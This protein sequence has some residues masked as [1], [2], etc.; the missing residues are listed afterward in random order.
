[1]RI[2]YLLFIILLS[3]SFICISNVDALTTTKV[4]VYGGTNIRN[5]TSNGY[6]N[7]IKAKYMDNLVIIN[8]KTISAKYCSKGL[9]KVK[10]NNIIGYV[11]SDSISS[12]NT[13]LVKSKT[14]LRNGKGTNY[15][16]YKKLSKNTMLTLKTTKV[17][18]KSR[19]C[20][21]GW[22]KVLIDGTTKY[23]CK[24]NT[25]RYTDKNTLLV[26]SKKGAILSKSK[27]NR[28]YTS[29]SYMSSL[30]LYKNKKYSGKNCPSKYYRVK[31]NNS[32]Y[33]VCSS[34]VLLSKTSGV[35]VSNGSLTVRSSN[36]SSS[37]QINTL[38]YSNLVGLINTTKYKGNGC[39][40]GFYKIYLDGRVGYA[41]SNFISTSNNVASTNKNISIKENSN[42]NSKN[43][44]S[45]N[46]NINVALLGIGKYSGS[47]CSS[48]YYK[49]TYDNR[50]GYICSGDTDFRN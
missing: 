33:Y 44:G 19:S 8:N 6:K 47:G 16:A 41:C 46:K 37:K 25:K 23:I 45:L 32:L 40:G 31:Y 15:K 48:G 28:K 14:Y 26:T 1:M 17:Y 30:T 24:N 35:V 43:I 21:K 38:Y 11:C 5:N 34:S 9:V 39:S 36:S 2:K 7:I 3:L 10:Y 49:I 22:Y 27:T 13:V 18:K 12:N 4:N 50:T 20:S 29:V 42:S